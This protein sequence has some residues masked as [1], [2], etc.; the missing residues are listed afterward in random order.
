MITYEGVELYLKFR[1]DGMMGMKKNVSPA[2]D[3]PVLD[4][5]LDGFFG[6]YRFDF[7]LVHAEEETIL[8]SRGVERP[9]PS[10]PFLFIRQVKRGQMS[11]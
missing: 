7:G 8:G 3:C 6:V 2:S 9:S 10:F 4:G 5:H 1:N 11:L